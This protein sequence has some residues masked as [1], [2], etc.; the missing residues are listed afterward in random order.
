[1]KKTIARISTA[2][3]LFLLALNSLSVNYVGDAYGDIIT[4]CAVIFTLSIAIYI[5]VFNKTNN[6][7]TSRYNQYTEHTTSEEDDELTPNNLFKRSSE[8]LSELLDIYDLSSQDV[9]NATTYYGILRSFGIDL[10]TMDEVTDEISNLDPPLDVYFILYNMLDF[11]EPYYSMVVR[12]IKNNA[13]IYYCLP[14]S[15]GMDDRDKSALVEKLIDDKDVSPSDVKS[16]L[17]F[18]E[19]ADPIFTT[20]ICLVNPQHENRRT[21]GYATI[22]GDDGNSVVAYNLTPVEIERNWQRVNF[23]ER[24]MDVPMNA[25]IS[26]VN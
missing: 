7:S 1:M 8:Q 16:S 15:R 20:N 22:R 24:L 4:Y 14:A 2:I 25:I 3:I 10:Y 17:F 9:L 13:N 18:K 23:G 5:L 6:D 19:L 21:L 11:Q 26:G 12:L